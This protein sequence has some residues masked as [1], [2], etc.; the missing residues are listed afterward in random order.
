MNFFQY[1]GLS[2]LIFGISIS[3]N[4]G[5]FFRLGCQ[6]WSAEQSRRGCTF[7]SCGFVSKAQVKRPYFSPGF[8]SYVGQ[9]GLEFPA[10]VEFT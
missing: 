5:E 6:I 4:F 10:K 7:A 2:N 1:G 9:H 3:A 8:R